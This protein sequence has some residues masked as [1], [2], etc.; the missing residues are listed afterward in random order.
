MSNIFLN[1]SPVELL[2]LT[3]YGE[4]RSEGVAGMKAIINVIL[5][6]IKNLKRFA[7]KNLLFK[8]PYH[9]VILKPYQFSMF[10]QSDL[11]YN[12]IKTISNNFNKY[13]LTDSY[14]NLAYQIAKSGIRGMLTDN[15]KGANH[16]HTIN[17]KP[18]WSSSLI[19]T[20]QIG[21]HVFYKTAKSMLKQ[22]TPYISITL[23]LLISGIS[24][25][26]LNKRK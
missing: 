12:K 1:K 24:L 17:I 25:Y 2:A 21:K 18:S 8:S 4:A 13:L 6:R 10:N 15:T 14:L 11:Q 3:A 5:N 16:Y 7:D 20:V 23:I 26:L 22:S 9:A 19:K